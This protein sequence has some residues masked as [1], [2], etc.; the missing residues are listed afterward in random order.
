MQET[1]L[2]RLVLLH[3]S[4]YIILARVTLVQFVMF[5]QHPINID[6][7]MRLTCRVLMMKVLLESTPKAR[8]RCTASS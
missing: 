8:N 2:P 5:P 1:I 7:H 3:S 6:V 4:W